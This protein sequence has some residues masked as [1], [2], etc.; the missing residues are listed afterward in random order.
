MKVEGVARVEVRT[1]SAH[2][3]GNEVVMED[4]V[5]LCWYTSWSFKLCV[6]MMRPWVINRRLTTFS[7]LQKC[8]FT[9]KAP[10]FR[11]AALAR[12]YSKNYRLSPATAISSE[13]HRI[14]S[15]LRS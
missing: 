1:I 3:G 13:N 7:Y 14:P 6:A 8:K 10:D 9:N 15:D 11:K 12:S 4:D 2:S 5:P